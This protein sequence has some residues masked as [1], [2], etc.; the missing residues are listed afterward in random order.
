MSTED[1]RTD[2][3]RLAAEAG[4]DRDLRVTGA[5]SGPDDAGDRAAAEGLSTTPKQDEHYREML[6]RG[7]H[8][9]GEGRVP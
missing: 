9:K 6:E 1:F 4:Q 2:D 5:G 8:Q 3:D 7:A